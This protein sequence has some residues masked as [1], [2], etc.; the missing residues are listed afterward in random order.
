MRKG[1]NNIYSIDLLDYDK[2]KKV[3]V[4]VGRKKC[5]FRC[6]RRQLRYVFKE[7]VLTKIVGLTI[8]IIMCQD[9][10][11]LEKPV[12]YVLCSGDDVIEFNILFFSKLNTAWENQNTHLYM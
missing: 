4:M 8:I 5:I 3:N 1:S 7:T 9:S 2:I 11:K 6:N 12:G 10:S